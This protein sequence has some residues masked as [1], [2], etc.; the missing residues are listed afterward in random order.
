MPVC[1]CIH[2]G[3]YIHK[4]YIINILPYTFHLINETFLLMYVEV[5]VS[6]PEDLSVIEGKSQL[7]KEL[8]AQ[9]E[10]GVQFCIQIES[11]M[12]TDIID[13]LTV[14]TGSYIYC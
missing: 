5:I 6:F 9:G 4:C 3:T 1:V 8:S 12:N 10:Y 2:T 7:S 14:A 11:R 13:A